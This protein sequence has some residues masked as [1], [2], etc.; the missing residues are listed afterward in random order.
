MIRAERKTDQEPAIGKGPLLEEGLG[1]FCKWRDARLVPV[2][3]PTCQNIFRGA[4]NA[5]NA[6]FVTLHGVVFDIL[7]LVAC[8]APAAM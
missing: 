6:E 4:L 5:Q 1:R 8:A 2:I 7:V 3:C